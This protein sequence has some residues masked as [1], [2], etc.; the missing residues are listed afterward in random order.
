MSGR[1][2]KSNPRIH[3]TDANY[4]EKA[5][6]H[7][8]KD[9]TGRCA[10][11]L[12]HTDLAGGE[13]CMEVDHF[14]PKKK[15]PKKAHSYKNLMLASRSCNLTKGEEWP[16][17]KMKKQGFEFINP[18]EEI[19]YGK[20]IFENIETGEL[21]AA[22]PKGCYQINKCMLNAKHLVTQRKERTEILALLKSHKPVSLPDSITSIKEA[23][24]ELE[25][26]ISKVSYIKEKY[27][28][29]IPPPPN[30]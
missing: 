12:V 20:H 28:P 4:R 11:S 30:K 22:T 19:D 26:L 10:Y 2:K 1:I 8:M 15:F 17:P 25:I 5:F 3:C 13:T 24:K 6:P 18:C 9:F 29:Y 14:K 7:L 16:S 23:E 21:V 27:I